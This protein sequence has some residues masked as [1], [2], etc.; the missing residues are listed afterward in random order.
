MRGPG[1]FCFPAVAALILCG[2]CTDRPPPTREIPNLGTRVRVMVPA[3]GPGWRTGIFN[4]TRQSPPCYLV[5]L[6]HP[7]PTLRIAVTVPIGAVTRLQVSVRDTSNHIR[8]DPSAASLEG[9]TWREVLPDSAQAI[10]RHCPSE[11]SNQD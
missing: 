5:L 7:G 10:S 2:A 6:F 8:F 1:A 11:P 4:Q 9:E 3:I